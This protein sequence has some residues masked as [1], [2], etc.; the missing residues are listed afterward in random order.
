MTNEVGPFNGGLQVIQRHSMFDIHGRTAKIVEFRHQSILDLYREHMPAKLPC[1]C[2]VSGGEV[3]PEEEW[4]TTMVSPNDSVLFVPVP[5]G[6]GGGGGKNG[7]T[8]I[9]GVLLVVAAVVAYIYAPYIAPWMQQAGLTLL[10]TETAVGYAAFAMGVMGMSMI[11]TGLV[12]AL[13]TPNNQ[14]AQASITSWSPQTTQ[15]QGGCI[16]RYYG[17]HKVTGNVLA[18]H[19]EN[20]G[21]SQYLHVM[22]CLG[23][24]PY[25]ELYD[26]KINDIDTPTLRGIRINTRMGLL[27]QE[28]LPGFTQTPVNISQP[29]NLVCPAGV[30]APCIRQ[31]DGDDFDQLTVS[32]LFPNGLGVVS[33]SGSI[34]PCSVQVEVKVKLATEGD[35]TYLGKEA[36]HYQ[37]EVEPGYWSQGNWTPDYSY[38]LGGGGQG[39]GPN[40]TDAS[41]NNSPG[42]GEDSDTGGV[43]SDSAC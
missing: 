8:T 28:I 37:E 40:G 36:V 11:M 9:I 3:I 4:A 16:P 20:F 41:N 31:T 35:W 5:H 13:A 19:V 29:Q 39:A 33:G 42:G 14:T 32:L 21:D 24:G 34:D 2:S 27:T 18:S 6:G 7:F 17:L 38:L 22:I 23:L 12:G 43:S 10:G 30:P 26:F 1:V 25:V 15:V